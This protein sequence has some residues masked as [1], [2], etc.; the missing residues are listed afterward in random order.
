MLQT[1]V[2]HREEQTG[3]Y[4]VIFAGITAQPRSSDTEGDVMHN[5]ILLTHKKEENNAT[6]SSVDGPRDY[7]TE[8]SQKEKGKYQVASRPCRI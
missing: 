4:Q 2:R 1:E 8:R 7:Y 3:A 6:C 5:G